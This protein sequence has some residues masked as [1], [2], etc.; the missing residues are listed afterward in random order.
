MTLNKRGAGARIT[1]ACEK[2]TP[3]IT[4]EFIK[5]ANYFC[6]EDTGEL[7]R[8]ALRASEPEKGLAVWDTPY[9]KKQLYIGKPSR[10]KNPNAS[11]LW[12]HRAKQ[13]N[14]RKYERMFQKIVKQEV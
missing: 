14:S 5:D 13:K 10:D 8:S 11:T 3:I 1:T 6:K 4:N 2:A 12:G 7:E 9:A